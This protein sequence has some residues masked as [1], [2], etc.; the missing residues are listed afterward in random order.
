TDSQQDSKLNIYSDIFSIDISN[1][2]C[3]SINL[4]YDNGAPTI[5]K[6]AFHAANYIDNYL[7][8]NSG[9]SEPAN[10]Y[11][12]VFIDTS[13]WTRKFQFKNIELVPTSDYISSKNEPKSNTNTII[14]S[15]VG[16]LL[17]LILS[18]LLYYFLIFRKRKRRELS[19]IQPLVNQINNQGP[20]VLWVRS[21]SKIIRLDNKAV[22][23]LE[24]KAINNESDREA[25]LHQLNSLNLVYKNNT[26]KQNNYSNN[27][28]ESS[29]NFT[30]STLINNENLD[31]DG[32]LTSSYLL[33]NNMRDFIK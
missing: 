3:T 10:E 7:Y 18:S 25:D 4:K 21:D 31:E 29:G 27:I 16:V 14:Y 6:R 24:D 12:Q 33:N 9:K 11:K 13:S 22:F 20:D 2:K 28:Q 23:S 15:V 32:T 1:F 26:S 30:S 8:I 19:N 17:F 5:I